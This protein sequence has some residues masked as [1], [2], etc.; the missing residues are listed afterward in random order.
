M[1]C[2]L[3]GVAAFL[4]CVIVA[5]IGVL[6]LAHRAKLDGIV[7]L[8]HPKK[9]TIRIRVIDTD[10]R[11][12]VSGARISFVLRDWMHLSDALESFDKVRVFEQQQLTDGG[13][14]VEIVREIPARS[15]RNTSRNR[16][17]LFERCWLKG[18]APGHPVVYLALEG[19]AGAV[20]RGYDDDT[21]LQVLMVMNKTPSAEV[22]ST[23]SPE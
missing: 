3:T 23:I 14:Y 5:L 17:L 16:E 18:E 1:R 11:L 12:P 13:G 15:T 2:A 22:E 4:F 10:E 8:Y 6:G 7:G 21:P 19:C 20:D 9:L